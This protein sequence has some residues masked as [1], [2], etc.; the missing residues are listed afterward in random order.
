MA[1]TITTGDLKILENAYHNGFLGVVDANKDILFGNPLTGDRPLGSVNGNVDIKRVKEI[2]TT[3]NISGI[4]F[5]DLSDINKHP[6]A[7]GDYIDMM[8][9][10]RV[11]GL[12]NDAN[13][14]ETREKETLKANKKAFATTLGVSSDTVDPGIIEGLK[15]DNVKEFVKKAD[16]ISLLADDRINEYVKGSKSTNREEFVKL[17]KFLTTDKQYVLK[18]LDLLTKP[19]VKNDVAHFSEVLAIAAE[20]PERISALFDRSDWETKISTLFDYDKERWKIGDQIL[21]LV[22]KDEDLDIDSIKKLKDKNLEKMLKLY[23]IKDENGRKI[24]AS[25]AENIIRYRFGILPRD[26]PKPL[27]GSTGKFI[28]FS[29]S[30][31]I[32]LI[33]IWISYQIF[34]IKNIK[35]V[36]NE[37]LDEDYPEDLPRINKIYTW[38]IVVCVLACIIISIFL[39]FCITLFY[40]KKTDKLI[41][42][43]PS[44]FLYFLMMISI[45]LIVCFTIAIIHKIGKINGDYD[46][47]NISIKAV[48]R[49]YFILLFIFICLFFLLLASGVLIYGS[50]TFFNYKGIIKTKGDDIEDYIDYI[51]PTNYNLNWELKDKEII[52]KELPSNLEWS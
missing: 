26:V 18:T 33:C 36:V 5:D 48:Y 29:L 50:G 10:N 12:L 1:D 51:N 24:T 4:V 39:I 20:N 25:T 8:K 38:S 15:D 32:I 44:K 19:I 43:K 21:R 14:I 11:T 37:Y 13:V 45:I 2:I 31:V 35:N 6:S 49:T 47:Y 3:K 22:E 16:I 34:Y 28:M 27:E 52:T 30:F 40:K 9:K 23:M 41:E 46:E 17:L 42:G 7:T